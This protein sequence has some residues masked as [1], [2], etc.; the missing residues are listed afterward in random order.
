MT[1]FSTAL[2]LLAA[3]APAPGYAGLKKKASVPQASAL[4]KYVNEANAAASMATTTPGSIYRDDGLLSDMTR[5]LRA[6]H[7]NDL[8]T[9]TVSEAASAVSTGNSKTSRQSSAKASVA[10]LGGITRATGPLT[11]LADL[12]GQHALDGQGTTSRSTSIT[13]D[14]SARVVGVLPNGYLVLEGVKE[15]EVNSERQTVTVRGVARW[16]DISSTNT[17]GSNS[18]AQLEVKINGK[19]IVGDAIRRPNFLYRLLLGILPF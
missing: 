3:L 9:I 2:L 17:I 1:R 12:S 18:L 6:R 5:D 14:L 15:V 7:L 13:T 19:G 8:V 11:N 16:N 4:D 10:A